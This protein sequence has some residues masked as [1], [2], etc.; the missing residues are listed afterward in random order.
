MI[1]HTIKKQIE[2]LKTNLPQND[3]LLLKN[4][5]TYES[6]YRE[7]FGKTKEVHFVQQGTCEWQTEYLEAWSTC[8]ITPRIKTLQLGPKWYAFSPINYDKISLQSNELFGDS[9]NKVFYVGPT[10]FNPDDIVLAPIIQVPSDLATL[11]AHRSV[12][13]TENH[14]WHESWTYCILATK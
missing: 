8:T 6:N 1:P 10:P 9:L 5:A 13:G 4:L 2:T 7:I 14:L 11:T 12:Y 3:D